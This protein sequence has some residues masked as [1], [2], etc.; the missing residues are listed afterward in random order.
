MT[1][2]RRIMDDKQPTIERWKPVNGYEGIYEVSDHGRVRS[3]D[4]TVTYSNGQ[5]HRYKGKILRTPLMQQTGYP[6]VSL[7][8]QGERQVRT[9]HSLVAETFIGTRPEGMEV[10]HNDGDRTNNHLDNLRYGTSSDNNLDQLRHGT[11]TNAAKTHCPLGHEL[12][13]ENIPPSI[14]KRGRRQCLACVRARAQ[15][16]YHP[17]L[18][19]QLKALADSYYQEILEERKIAA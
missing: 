10:C 16:N 15:V 18:K 5:V 2:L 9:V 7:H 8:I 12:F 14:A 17:E 6:F 1:K 19:P 11:H 4:R 3:I 13:A